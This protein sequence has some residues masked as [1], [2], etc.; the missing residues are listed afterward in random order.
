MHSKKYLI[1]LSLVSTAI[2]ATVVFKFGESKTIYVKNSGSSAS[3]T[4]L[5]NAENK[6]GDFSNTIIPLIKNP[7]NITEDF[8]ANLTRQII[9]KNDNIQVGDLL[10]GPGINMPDPNKIAEDFITSG[11]KTA[12]DNILNIDPPNLTVSS[13]NSKTAIESY[14]TDIQKIL[15]DNLKDGD[16]LLLILEDIQKNNG[17]GIE[18]L[19]PIISAHEA[20]ASQIEAITVPSSLKDLM[21]EEV[22]M[23]KITANILKPLTNIEA[24][25][26]ATIAA[27]GQFKTAVDSWQSLQKKFDAFIQKLNRT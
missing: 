20:A 25:P 21:A 19:Y 6:I 14:L 27:I 12:N 26:L 4:Q 7:I 11:L 9:S 10:P 3:P 13:G 5:A 24:D 18:K 23:L 1:L 16:S 2:V 15:N 22:R 17:E 8:A